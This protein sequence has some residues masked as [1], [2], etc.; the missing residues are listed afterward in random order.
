[1]SRVHVV[2]HTNLT[3]EMNG[4]KMVKAHFQSEL[5]VWIKVEVRHNVWNKA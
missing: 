4:A 1:M 3:K 2:L 5:R